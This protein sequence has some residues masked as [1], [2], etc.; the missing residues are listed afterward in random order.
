MIDLD[1]TY[2]RLARPWTHTELAAHYRSRRTS[3]SGVLRPVGRSHATY[4]TPGHRDPSGR[5]PQRGDPRAPRIAHGARHDITQDLVASAAAKAANALHR[6]HR[7]LELDGERYD[8]DAEAWLPTIYDIVTPA[9]ESARP[10]QD[11]PT[12]G[13]AASAGGDPL[14]LLRH[15]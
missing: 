7:A 2:C 1:D 8:Y 13:G 9:L 3:R 14:A 12:N 11:P 4:R 5:H 6:C 15:A 10:D